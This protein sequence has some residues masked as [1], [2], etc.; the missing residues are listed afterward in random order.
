MGLH[1]S[2]ID[3]ERLPRRGERGGGILGFER[4]GEPQVRGSPLRIELER[5]LERR[6]SIPGRELLQEQLAPRRLHSGIVTRRGL[7]AAQ[8]R[9]RAA[10]L[11]ERL[12][13]TPAT[14]YASGVRTSAAA[15]TS[16]A[17]SARASPLR[18][19]VM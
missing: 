19:S 10:G 6:G 3:L 2:R 17:S 8:E 5:G 18:P 4:P 11:P 14:Q 9:V 1:E 16:G 15:S 7:R 13:G 12:R